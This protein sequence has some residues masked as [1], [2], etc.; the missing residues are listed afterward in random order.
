MSFPAPVTQVTGD[1][2]GLLQQPGR[3]RVLA[4]QPPDA[5][6]LGEGLGDEGR[7][8]HLLLLD[9]GGITKYDLPGVLLRTRRNG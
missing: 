2:Q 6:E 4:H 9:G 1:S 7:A 5:P 3:G 8:D